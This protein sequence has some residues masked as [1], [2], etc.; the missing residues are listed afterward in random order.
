LITVANFVFMADHASFQSGT[1]HRLAAMQHLSPFLQ[2]RGQDNAHNVPHD[3]CLLSLRHRW[4][5]K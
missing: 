1:S 3:T 2:V 5:Y 4:H